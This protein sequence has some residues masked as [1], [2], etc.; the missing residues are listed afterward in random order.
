MRGSVYRKFGA[1]RKKSGWM[2]GNP[3]LAAFLLSNGVLRITMKKTAAQ[4]DKR[5]TVR[6]AAAVPLLL[7]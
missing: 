3:Y 2:W 6:E 1:L 7:G 4:E 5:M